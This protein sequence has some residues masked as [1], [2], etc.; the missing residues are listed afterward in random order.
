MMRKIMCCLAAGLLMLAAAWGQTPEEIIARM[1]KALE[2]AESQGLSMAMDFKIPIIGT[3]TTQV[4]I[5]GEKTR[6]ETRI[7]GHELVT[8][9]D[10]ITDWEYDSTKKEL[11][12]G[13]AKPAKEADGSEAGMFEGI[14]EGY[15][16]SLQKETADAWHLRCHK[17]KNNPEKDAPARMDLVV[18]K[19]THLPISLTA[20][21]TGVKIVLHDLA[22]GVDPAKVTF[23]MEDY[24]DAKIIDKR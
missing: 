2:P 1:E 12:I 8:F 7:L 11:T 6:S 4:Y 21:I 23:R 20:K 15:D 13:K 10:G 18:S 22:V 19:K 5:L 3:S 24:P 14:M 16:V 9:S 17:A